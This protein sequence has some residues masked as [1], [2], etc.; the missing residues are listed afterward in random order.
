MK[1]KKISKETIVCILIIILLYV[2]SAL[3]LWAAYRDAASKHTSSVA[4]NDIP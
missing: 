2:G 1:R 4:Q 3:P